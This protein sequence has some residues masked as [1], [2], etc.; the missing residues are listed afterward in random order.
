[1]CKMENDKNSYGKRTP[2]RTS[3][4]LTDMNGNPVKGNLSVAITDK[5]MAV[6]DT[7]HSILSTLLLSSELKGRI[8]T[9]SFYLQ[10]DNP[11]AEKA[12]DLLLMI[13]GW[14]RYRLPE[15]IKGNFEK[16]A[17][18]PERLLPYPEG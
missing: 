10:T 9:P 13:H 17:M 11:E 3:L 15:I 6:A 4:L 12:L 18:E 5:S 2:V 14:K 8:E 16:P 7:T 1:M